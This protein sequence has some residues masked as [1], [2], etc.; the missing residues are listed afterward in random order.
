MVKESDIQVSAGG[1]EFFSH[2]PILGTRGGITAG[3]IM[4]ADDTCGITK[5]SGFIHFA[6]A[7]GSAVECTNVAGID[8]NETVFA[9]QTEYP[10][11]LSVCLA[12]QWAHQGKYIRAIGK[13][14]VILCGDTSVSDERYLIPRDAIHEDSDTC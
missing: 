11:V 8:T 6:G 9:I 12:G 2:A 13:A 3:V 7:D 14:R 5:Y 4:T 1:V 10:E